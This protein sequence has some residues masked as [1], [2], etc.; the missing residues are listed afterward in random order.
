MFKE[1]LQSSIS[2]HSRELVAWNGDSTL[3]TFETKYGRKVLVLVVLLDHMEL[4][5]TIS[6]KNILA[7]GALRPC[8]SWCTN[9]V[10]LMNTML[11]LSSWVLAVLM[12]SRWKT[13]LQ[14]YVFLFWVVGVVRIQI[15]YALCLRQKQ[16]I[17]FC[18]D[19]A[20]IQNG[21]VIWSTCYNSWSRTL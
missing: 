11:R 5:V 15:G 21:F 17:T 20:C 4:H 19:V 18:Q 12:M 8:V 9:Q 10:F 2:S 13:E 7:N 14:Q 16:A 1:N 3:L 6:I